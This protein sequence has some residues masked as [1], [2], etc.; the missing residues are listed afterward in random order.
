MVDVNIFSTIL[1]CICGGVELKYTKAIDVLVNNAC[2]S[3]RYRTRKEILGENAKSPI[4]IELQ[5]EI[6][7]DENV[8]NILALKQEDG[9]LGG[10]FHG[11]LEPESA[12]RYLSEKGVEGNHPTIVGALNA[13]V[14]RGEYF[15]KGSM[16]RVGKLLD[17]YH[18]GGSKMI[19][20]CVFAY[21]GHV[22]NAFV[23]EEITEALSAFEFISNVENL[24]QIY[25]I[26]KDKT[27]VFNEETKWP[28]IYHLRL[29]SFSDGWK[30]PGNKK[31]L[32]AAFN[33]LTNFSPIPHIKLLFKNQI[34]SPAYIYM[35]DFNVNMNNLT[36][37]ELMMWFHRTEMIARLGIINDVPEI[38][39]QIYYLNEY[40]NANNGFFVEKISHFYF[41]KWTQYIGLALENDWNV[42]DSRINDLTF[43]SLLILK[44]SN[45]L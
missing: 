20:A 2:P 19:K 8:Q 30:N 14:N 33:K 26:Y 28:S 39:K 12:I 15:D 25:H 17:S 43:R 18:L 13:I 22:D 6:L 45:L 3:I 37:K 11:E 24:N 23:E 4:M 29:L 41:N 1:I 34:I 36:P 32:I 40:L 35:N 21:S 10:L 42:K 9:W 31:M 38:K 7:E 44:F 16:E 5:K 27:C